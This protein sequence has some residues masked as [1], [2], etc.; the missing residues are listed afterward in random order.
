MAV[1]EITGRR[2]VRWTGKPVTLTIPF[3]VADKVTRAVSR[4]LAYWVPPSYPE[5]IERLRVHGI[6]METITTPRDIDTEMYRLD[7]ATL[8][9]SPYEG[10]VRVERTKLNVHKHRTTFPAGSVRVPTDQPLGDLAVVLLEPA[11]P[12]SFYQWGFFLEV[13]ARTEYAEAYVMEPMAQKMLNADPKLRQ[14]FER[15]LTNDKDFASSA[16]NRLDF[17]YQ[18]TP[19]FDNRYLLYPIAR[20]TTQP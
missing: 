13:L 2:Y 3:L 15:Q 5:V 17:F 4:P 10:H 19:Y 16:R 7:N 9:S 8:A 12:D 18:R 14:Q 20:E 1:S 6:Q 11:S